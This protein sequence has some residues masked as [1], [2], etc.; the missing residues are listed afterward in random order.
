LYEVTALDPLTFGTVG[1]LL[2][3][4]A[5]AAAYLPARRASRISAAEALRSAD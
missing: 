5:A 3:A 1:A 4:A 2:A